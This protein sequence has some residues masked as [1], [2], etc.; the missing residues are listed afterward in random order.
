MSLQ[1]QAL[2]ECEVC[3]E[4]M[5]RNGLSLFRSALRSI[6]VSIDTMH[7]DVDQYS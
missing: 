7:V 1:T 2:A 4:R 3:M 5:R 6:R